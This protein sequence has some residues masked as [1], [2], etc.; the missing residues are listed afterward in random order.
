M[1]HS[2]E[3]GSGEEGGA[4]LLALHHL[5]AELGTLLGVLQDG[6]DLDGAGPVGVVEALR[7]DQLLQVSLLELAGGVDDLVVVGDDAALGRLLAHDEEVVVLADHL[8]VDEGPGGHVLGLLPRREEPLAVPEVDHHAGQPHVRAGVGLPHGLLQPPA[9]VLLDEVDLVPGHGQHEDDELLGRALVPD[10]VGLHALGGHRQHVLVLVPSRGDV[11]GGRGEQREGGVGGPAGREAGLASLG[12]GVEA[13]DAGLVEDVVELGLEGGHPEDVAPLGGHLEEEL[14][15][16]ALGPLL[17]EGVLDHELADHLLAGLEAEQLLL[18]PGVGALEV[19]G[20]DDHEDVDLVVVLE[21]LLDARD[22][23]SVLEH[24][25]LLLLD[26]QLQLQLLGGALEGG[27]HR[28]DV[29]VLGVEDCEGQAVLGGVERLAKKLE[30]SL[31]VLLDGL[32]VAQFESWIRDLA[33]L[34]SAHL[35]VE[36]DSQLVEPGQFPP[37]SQFPHKTVDL[38]LLVL[39]VQ[40][41]LLADLLPPLLVEVVWYTGEA[42]KLGDEVGWPRTCASTFPPLNLVLHEEERL[43]LMPDVEIVAAAVVLLEVWDFLTDGDLQHA[44]EVHIDDP[45]KGR[46][47]VVGH[48]YGADEDP[49]ELVA[50][51]LLVLPGV[52]LV[53]RVDHVQHGVLPHDFAGSINSKKHALLALLEGRAEA[54]EH[55][56]V[57]DVLGLLGGEVL[58]RSAD[59]DVLPPAHDAPQGDVEELQEHRLVV[60]VVDFPLADGHAVL[61]SCGFEGAGTFLR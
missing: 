32:L 2:D 3:V 8:R 12:G 11:D 30:E 34:D 41:G 33:G 28:P 4:D 44:L 40:D 58:A 7:V 14:G 24:R 35:L 59:L 10:R 21:G 42:A 54:L 47:A 29:S 15:V 60:E 13:H 16:D 56:E 22:D 55:L 45:V 17:A 37:F 46:F 23:V 53:D 48:D 49:F 38:L 19:A 9:E 52:D 39:G 5:S 36:G 31:L 50:L 27:D 57:V 61:T 1:D 25:C 51:L 26:H 43:A 6:G 20:Q 18:D